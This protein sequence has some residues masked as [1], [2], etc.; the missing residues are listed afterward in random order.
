MGQGT[1]VKLSQKSIGGIGQDT[2]LHAAEIRRTPWKSSQLYFVLEG[3]GVFAES[4]I[5]LHLLT[6]YEFQFQVVVS[7]GGS[8]AAVWWWFQQIFTAPIV[9][10][11]WWFQIGFKCLFFVLGMGGPTAPRKC[12]PN[13]PNVVNQNWKSLTHIDP[14]KIN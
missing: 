6:Q 3:G 13:T 12:G 4:G 14:I 2:V 11:G 9:V 8:Q 1:L 7:F 5:F 10:A